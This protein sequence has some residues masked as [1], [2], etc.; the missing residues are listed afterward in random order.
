MASKAKVNANP[1]VDQYRT[2]FSQ[3][4]TDVAKVYNLATMGGESAED[5]TELVVAVFVELIEKKGLDYVKNAIHGSEKA[6]RKAKAVARAQANRAI[7]DKYNDND[8]N[9]AEI[10]AVHSELEA[11]ETARAK[12][13][14]TLAKLRDKVTAELDVEW[15][16]DVQLLT[17]ESGEP[18]VFVPED[19]LGRKP[20]KKGGTI[21]RKERIYDFSKGKWTKTVKPAAQLKKRD[22]NNKVV[23][24]LET[25]EPIMIDNPYA[26]Q[27][28]EWTIT[29]DADGF[30]VTLEWP[31]GGK[32][33]A[34]S[35]SMNDAGKDCKCE[36]HEAITGEAVTHKDITL[37]LMTM[38]GEKEIPYVYAEV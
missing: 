4:A 28:Q 9:R 30:H 32:A 16:L 33:E 19:S 5:A 13:K 7:L 37:N 8:E 1:L 36:Y 2:I 21:E 12:A 35:D 34:T 38:L 17:S 29:H 23:H 25:G 10:A 3:T 27:T 31:N 14:A 11:A 15:D 20:K 22:E 18:Y 6:A 26:G 24:D